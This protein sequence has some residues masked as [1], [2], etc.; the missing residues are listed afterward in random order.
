VVVV[1]L[2][3]FTEM[4]PCLITLLFYV[5]FKVTVINSYCRLNKLREVIRSFYT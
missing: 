2:L 4:L 3:G 1:L 5:T